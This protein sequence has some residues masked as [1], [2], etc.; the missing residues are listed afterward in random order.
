MLLP[1][2]TLYDCF[3]PRGLDPLLHATY[4]RARFL[5][6]AS[7][8]GITL[9]PEG[10]AHQSVLTPGLGL[11]VP[12]L[13]AYEPAFAREV[14]WLCLAALR[15]IQD[16]VHGRAVYLRLSTKVVDQALLEPALTRLGEAALREAA[17]SGGYRLVDHRGRDGYEPGANVVNLVAVGVMV[18]EAVAASRLLEAEGIYANVLVLTSPRR[19][20]E[21]WR[22]GLDARI[23]RSAVRPP[24]G[25]GRLV[26]GDEVEGQ[27]PLISVLDGH[28]HA[29]AWLGA[30]VGV[31]QV[32]LGV[33]DFGQSG[34]R[35]DLY[36]HYGI[37]AETIAAAARLVLS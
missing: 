26:S 33:D 31:P 6:V 30:A 1:I 22:G 18:P 4:S 5:L 7:P 29:L 3:L 34:A 24:A 2:G 21:A 8:S 36:R 12:N 32:P 19:W 16:P 14:E 37:D 20:Y 28:S 9:A 11:E 10:G 17:L 23:R 25:P 13:L 15:Q 35:D 27:V